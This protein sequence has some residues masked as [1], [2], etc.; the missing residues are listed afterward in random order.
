V[1][2]PKRPRRKSQEDN[3]LDDVFE[4]VGL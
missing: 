2:V 1:Q 3:D 4:K